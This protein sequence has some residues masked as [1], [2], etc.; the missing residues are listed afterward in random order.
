MRLLTGQ[1]VADAG[2][3]RVLGHELANDDRQQELVDDFIAGLEAAP[4]PDGSAS[5]AAPAGS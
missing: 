4:T 1:A 2:R 3:L 5:T